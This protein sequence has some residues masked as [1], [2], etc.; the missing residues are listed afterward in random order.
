MNNLKN[1][2]QKNE[3]ESYVHWILRLLTDII[4]VS[5]C[6]FHLYTAYF[7]LLGGIKQRTVHLAFAL[8][9]CFRLYP[10]FKQNNTRT[11][12]V[13]SNVISFLLLVGG[14]SSSI[15][16]FLQDANLP[17][18]AG[19]VVFEDVIFGVIMIIAILEGT[20]RAIGF[21]M[22]L[23]STICLIYCYFGKYMPSVIAHSGFDL[24]GIV[25]IVYLTT[26]GIYGVA[27]YVAATFIFLFI[28]L[29]QLLKEIGMGQFFIDIACKLFG[30]IRGGPA[31]IAVVAS[32]FFGTISGSAVANVTST[33]SFT[34]PLMIELGYPSY[35]AGAVEAVASAGGQFM[36]PVM[37]SASFVIA[38]ILGLPYYKV[39]L[40]A[41][42]P[43][44]F[45]YFC[46]FLQVD[47]YAV[48][49]NFVRLTKEDLEKISWKS[50]AAKSYFL[51][52]IVVLLWILVVLKSTPSKAA[53]WTITST[54]VVSLMSKKTRINV[55]KLISAFKNA[56]KTMVM[57]SMACANVGIIIG[58]LMLT[59]IG[60]KFSTMLV[61]LSHGNI[62]CLLFLTMISSLILGMGVPSLVCYLLL[63]LIVAPALILMGVEP[64]VAH[65][66][67]F[68]FGI[69]SCITPPVAITAYAAAGIAGSNP[70]KTG[71][72]A[73]RLGL[74][75]FIVPFFM[76]YH[77][78]LVVMDSSFIQILNGII[79]GLMM[80]FALASSLEGFMFRRINL[81]WRILLLMVAIMV[82]PNIIILNLFALGLF[83]I[84]IVINYWEVKRAKT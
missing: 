56:G 43:A 1:L 36:P 38:E 24:K 49:A 16:M 70:T 81:L 50:L 75:G 45:F 13:I 47:L 30:S 11:K 4:L 60:L 25:N 17:L 80:V 27:I 3:D 7:G 73:F 9:L 64:L 41:T 29:A 34:I 6:I 10:I 32:S 21:P 28:I 72:M 53:I 65:L 84:I 54:L 55:F 74:V 2:Y 35:Y 8:V 76:V 48:K 69:I 52:P 77:P 44:V 19:T 37:A 15:Y 40:G 18:R 22:C 78:S 26:E 82:I 31:K 42:I 39:I 57:I 79:I 68:Y 83:I 61:R 62:P 66:F 20:R 14:L 12:K 58:S 67:I 63:A 51:L 23:A 33:G 5:W 71:F 59:G 46:L